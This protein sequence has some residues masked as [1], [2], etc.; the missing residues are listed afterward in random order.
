MS[1]GIGEVAFVHGLPDSVTLV[2]GIVTQLG[3]VWFLAAVAVALYWFG[4]DAPWLTS[5]GRRDGSFAF[6]L[7]LGAYA[8]ALLLKT[9]FALPRPPG[10]GQ[11]VVPTWLPGIV[12]PIYESMV[13]GHG[14]GF[15]SGHAL[16]TTVVYG[17]LASTLRVWDARRRQMVAAGVV[18]LV[19]LARVVLGVHY[20]VDVVAGVAVGLVALWAVLRLARGR[21]R[22]AFVPPVVFGTLAFATM[23]STRAVAVVA[24]ALVGYFGVRSMDDP[25]RNDNPERVGD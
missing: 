7:L 13:T 24:V 6:A 5:D 8:L 3:D 2:F 4:R 15:P 25:S 14:Y 21:P 9:W 20:V 12:G 19:S 23:G 18:G 22:R 10:A 17:G 16:A 11:A 1:R